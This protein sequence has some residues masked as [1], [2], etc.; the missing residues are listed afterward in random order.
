MTGH[1]ITP[2][3]TKGIH[4]LRDHFEMRCRSEA[5]AQAIEG[6]TVEIL[7]TDPPE[8][9]G[10]QQL[11]L[12]IADEGA[13]SDIEMLCRQTVCRDRGTWYDT[14]IVQEEDVATVERAKRYLQLRGMGTLGFRVERHAA[15][16][17]LIRFQGT[18][19]P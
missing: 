6:N 2:S 12:E 18:T 14:G 4:E 19:T 5:P 13:R 1:H 9:I 7:A 16:P 11:A 17:N 10:L 8:Q 15:F 3:A